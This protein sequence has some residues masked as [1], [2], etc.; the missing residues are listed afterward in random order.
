MGEEAH[1]SS[2]IFLR[3]VIV[4]DKNVRYPNIRCFFCAFASKDRIRAPGESGG[5]DGLPDG[6]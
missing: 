3:G 4:P 5:R 1:A 6:A 2:M